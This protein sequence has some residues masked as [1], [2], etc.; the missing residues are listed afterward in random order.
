MNH[1]NLTCNKLTVMA[2]YPFSTSKG[3]PQV[4]CHR[5]DGKDPV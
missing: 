4:N 5:I 3:Q 2:K 1:K